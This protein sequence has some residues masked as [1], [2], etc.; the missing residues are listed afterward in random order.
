[1]DATGVMPTLEAATHVTYQFWN[2][3]EM[4]DYCKELREKA[5]PKLENHSDHEWDEYDEEQRQK[6]RDYR[7]RMG[8]DPAWVAKQR[9][10]NKKSKLKKSYKSRS[11]KTLWQ[12][13]REL[14]KHTLTA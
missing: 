1:M 13:D 10:G 12:L 8:K 6:Q 2:D 5:E 4:C 3:G 7:A 9:E 11:R 14:P